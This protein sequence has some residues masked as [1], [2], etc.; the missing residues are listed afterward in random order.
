[1]PSVNT[2]HWSIIVHAG[3]LYNSRAYPSRWNQLAQMMQEEN[4]ETGQC[5]RTGCF[6][7][8]PGESKTLQLHK[9]ESATLESDPCVEYYCTVRVFI[10]CEVIMNYYAMCSRG[11]NIIII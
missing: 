4:A 9:F 2:L 1:M 6:V 5:G 3:S 10:K 8:V 11:Y 7:D